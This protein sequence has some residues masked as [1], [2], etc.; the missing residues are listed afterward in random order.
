MYTYLPTLPT[1]TYLL[2]IG[3]SLGA[4]ISTSLH[5]SI[6]YVQPSFL[7]PSTYS[8]VHI[9]DH[10]LPQ[11]PVRDDQVLDQT[12][13]TIFYDASPTTVSWHRSSAAPCASPLPPCPPAL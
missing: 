8:F 12:K 11:S 13:A 1:P 6:P 10:R 2:L 9:S 7:F 4:C 5:L 3:A